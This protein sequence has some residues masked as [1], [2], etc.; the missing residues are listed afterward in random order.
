[1]GGRWDGAPGP[2]FMYS[3]VVVTTWATRIRERSQSA[4]EQRGGHDVLSFIIPN[5]DDDRARRTPPLAHSARWNRWVNKWA[6]KMNGKAAEEAMYINR[7]ISTWCKQP[8]EVEN[9]VHLCVR[10]TKCSVG[11]PRSNHWNRK[12][13]SPGRRWG[14]FRGF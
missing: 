6:R 14:S 3:C 9:Y 4:T 2:T 11:S 1:M 13:D 8:D 12:R 5:N 7:K 10:V